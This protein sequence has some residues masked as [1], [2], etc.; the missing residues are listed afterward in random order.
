MHDVKAID[1]GDNLINIE[2][3]KIEMEKSKEELKRPLKKLVNL[4]MN[5]IKTFMF[6]GIPMK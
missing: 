1:P 4:G 3:E 5:F 6:L 2:I